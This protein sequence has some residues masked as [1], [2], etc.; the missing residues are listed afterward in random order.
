MVMNMNNMEK[1]IEDMTRDLSW[2]ISATHREAFAKAVKS[3]LIEVYEET[4]KINIIQN[5]SQKKAPSIVIN[6]EKIEIH[7]K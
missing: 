2:Y 4:M 5:N 6:I 1:I 3:A 7:N